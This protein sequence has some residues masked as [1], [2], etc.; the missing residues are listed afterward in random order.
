MGDN[1][2]YLFNLR[3]NICKSWRWDTH[4]NFKNSDLIGQWTRLKSTI[5]LCVLRVKILWFFVFAKQWGSV[6]QWSSDHSASLRTDNPD[7]S[8]SISDLAGRGSLWLCRWSVPSFSKCWFPHCCLCYCTYTLCGRLYS[9]FAEGG[10]MCALL[11]TELSYWWK[12]SR[13]TNPGVRKTWVDMLDH[14]SNSRK[15]IVKMATGKTWYQYICTSWP[16]FMIQ[17][18][19]LM[20]NQLKRVLRWLEV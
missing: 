13:G 20:L 1:Y 19:S 3:S 14:G 6:I 15:T 8:G 9:P 12:A 2:S 11:G 18:S 5:V 17:M 4:F 10:V 16:I 7:L